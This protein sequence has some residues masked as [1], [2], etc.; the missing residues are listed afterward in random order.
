MIWQFSIIHIKNQFF[1]GK[2]RR[3]KILNHLTGLISSGEYQVL[4]FTCHAEDYSAGHVDN[5]IKL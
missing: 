5:Q 3:D 4:V 1:R 2:W